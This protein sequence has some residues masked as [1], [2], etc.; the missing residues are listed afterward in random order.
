MAY[1][2]FRS[3]RLFDGY[4]FRLPDQV[5]VMRADGRF[6]GIVDV[7]DAGDD[8]ELVDGILSPG[9]I[10]CHCH[11]ELSHMRGLIPEGTGLVP[12]VQEVMKNRFMPEDR[13]LQAISDGEEEMLAHGIVA[14]G[15]ICNTAHTVMQKGKGRMH[16]HNFIEVSGFD[17]AIAQARIEQARSLL[18]RFNMVGKSS[19]VPHS[20]YSVSAQLWDLVLEQPASELFSIHNQEDPAEN[21]FFQSGSGAFTD[22]FAKM[23]LDLGFFKAPGTSSIRSYLH[24]FSGG[25]QVIFVHNVFTSAADLDYLQTLA[26]KPSSFWCLCPQANRY[27]STV[28]PDLPLLMQDG[29]MIVLGTDSLASNHSLDLMS[30]ITLLKGFYPDLRD[31][32]LLTW[33]TSNGAKALKVDDR[34]GSFEEGRKP[35][36]VLIDGQLSGARRL[37]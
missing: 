25:Q 23:K 37:L 30:E 9:L 26:G 15:D 32:T 19:I 12:F 27:I 6:E 16:Y 10:N 8:I 33:A 13:I 22:L 5:L 28:L 17:P 36:V 24:R 11:L 20:P 29:R 1:R 21:E 18:T 31:E 2:K 4:R 3:N 34:F 14:V 7:A 35:G